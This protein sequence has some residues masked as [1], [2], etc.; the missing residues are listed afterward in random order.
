MRERHGC[1]IVVFVLTWLHYHTRYKCTRNRREI[2]GSTDEWWWQQ[3]KKRKLEYTLEAQ[4]WRVYLGELSLR[5]LL[6]NIRSVLCA[7]ES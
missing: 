3:E 7:S 2:H 4:L 6:E 1:E 5:A